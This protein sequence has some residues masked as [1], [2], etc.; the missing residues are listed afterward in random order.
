VAYLHQSEEILL[1]T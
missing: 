1:I